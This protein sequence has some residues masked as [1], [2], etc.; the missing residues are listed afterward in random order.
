MSVV[1]D[2]TLFL[3]QTLQNGQVNPLR[4]SQLIA[5]IETQKAQ[6]DARGSGVEDGGTA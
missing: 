2:A 6:E 5:E 4:L 1:T 3:L